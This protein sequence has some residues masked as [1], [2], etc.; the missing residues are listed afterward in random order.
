[1]VP[2]GCP[3]VRLVGLDVP[4]ERL[5]QVPGWPDKGKAL[6]SA[7]MGEQGGHL[8]GAKEYLGRKG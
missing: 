8:L 1:M 6:L 2:C 4:G 3:Q 5:E 7:C